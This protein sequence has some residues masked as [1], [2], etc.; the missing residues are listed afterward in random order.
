MAKTHSRTGGVFLK[1]SFRSIPSL[2]DRLCWYMRSLLVCLLIFDTK[3]QRIDE[4]KFLGNGIAQCA[5]V[6]TVLPVRNSL[7]SDSLSDC[8]ER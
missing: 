6:C 8:T 4:W 2:I 5:E 3:L 7:E 1:K